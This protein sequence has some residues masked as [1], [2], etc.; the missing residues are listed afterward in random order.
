MIFFARIVVSCR[1]F[2]QG[3]YGSIIPSFV[4]ITYVVSGYQ[5]LGAEFLNEMVITIVS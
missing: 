3:F 5:V 1:N 2:V 4:I